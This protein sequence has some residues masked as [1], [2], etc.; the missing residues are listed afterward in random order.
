[1]FFP[2]YLRALPGLNISRNAIADT[3]IAKEIGPIQVFV[4]EQWSPKLLLEA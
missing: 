3:K 4:I 1:M 2:G